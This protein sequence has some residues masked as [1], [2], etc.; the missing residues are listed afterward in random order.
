[1]RNNIVLGSADNTEPIYTNGRVYFNMTG[2]VCRTDTNEK[3]NLVVIL[4]CDYSTHITYPV[5]LMPYVSFFLYF[6]FASQH[7]SI[8]FR[9]IN[10]MNLSICR[11]MINA[12]W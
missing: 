10:C 12:F 3:Y 7:F 9:K 11:M 1:M 2:D 8:T 5:M 6:R 4:V